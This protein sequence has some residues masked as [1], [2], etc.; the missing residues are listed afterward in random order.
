MK[1]SKPETEVEASASRGF[2]GDEEIVE[3]RAEDVIVP[4]DDRLPPG[5]AVDGLLT[6][7]PEKA[8]QVRDE[9]DAALDQ[10]NDDG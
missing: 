8:E 2:T 4:N 5:E 9:I 1:E 3:L 10:F 6:P 7:T